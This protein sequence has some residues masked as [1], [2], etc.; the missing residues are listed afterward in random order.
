MCAAILT[1]RPSGSKSRDP[2]E[3]VSVG[4]HNGSE[5]ASGAVPRCENTSMT[6]A[7]EEVWLSD[8]PL[9][10]LDDSS[11]FGRA[12]LVQR[13]L[14]VLQRIRQQSQS[15]TIGLIGA[16]GSGKTTVLQGLVKQ[17]NAPESGSESVLGEQWSVAQFNPWLYSD[18]VA[19]HAGFFAELRSSLPKGKRWKET[20]ASVAAL[21]K[22]LA[23]LSALTGLV[24]VNSEQAIGSLV[25]QIT[26]SAAEQHKRVAKEL[27][28]LNHPVLMVIDDLDRL[29]AGEL[30][31]VFKLV[32]LVGRLPNVYYLLSYDEQ[33]VVDL[34]GKTDLVSAKDDRRAL[35]YL[36]K[37]VQVRLDMPTLRDYEVDRVVSR[38]L[39]HITSR[40]GLDVTENELAEL[41]RRFDGVLSKRLRTPRAIKRYFGQLDAFLPGVGS[42][43]LFRDFAVLTWLRTVEPGVY[44]LIQATKD[45]LLG[46]GRDAL[47]S[48]TQPKLTN[49][50]ERVIWLERLEGARVAAEHLDD[51][52]YLL[53]T[54]FPKL[55]PVYRDDD[56]ASTRDRLGPT[57]QIRSIAHADYFD[58]Y[59]TFGVPDDDIPDGT[60]A[61][62]LRE[63]SASAADR[64]HLAQV[65]GTFSHQPELVIRKIWS[66]IE[67]EDLDRPALIRWLAQRHAQA[68]EQDTV[69]HRIEGLVANILGELAAEI[70]TPLMLEVA[71]T[72]PGSHL[73]GMVR[74][75]LAIDVVG[76]QRVVQR[77]NELAAAMTAPLVEHYRHYFDQEMRS[78]GSPFDI[79]TEGAA[80]IWLWRE[81]DPAGLRELLRTAVEEDRWALLDE[82]AWL[83]P[84]NISAKQER[85]ISRYND[86]DHFAELFDLDG[87]AVAL[88][89]E[90]ETAGTLE[91]YRDV[92]ATPE[93]Q[94]GYALALLKYR[95]DA[96]AA[97]PE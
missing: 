76:D 17:I 7:F 91:Q 5:Q 26:V 13:I 28:S 68:P 39:K 64:P 77:H 94:R 37:I 86:L 24:G 96:S 49:K 92:E 66:R 78:T 27:Q 74:H 46:I 15:T 61:A 58:R 33:T 36:E 62:A 59:F 16:W 45:L 80:L 11:L 19:L 83:V 93:H 85:F 44:N 70:V 69:R 3:S 72:V 30:L 79:P 53:S 38:S 1:I 63:L 29:S 42:E 51:V 41:I 21:G 71:V 31:Q 97:G 32:R 40:H 73:W 12:I 50:Q 48:L 75:L 4:G 95:R 81:I 25:E 23:P 56:T 60:V 6:R 89:D 67:D 2:G 34:L 65:E 47:R 57:P 84:V 54:L 88:H 8:D 90:V 82:L 18:A 9:T 87:A 43:V 20:R 22:R 10:E 14:E 55:D 35:D 52:L